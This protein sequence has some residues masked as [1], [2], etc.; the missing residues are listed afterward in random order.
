MKR[1]LIKLE[2]KGYLTVRH[3]QIY[4]YSAQ[5]AIDR[6]R[7]IYDIERVCEVWEKVNDWK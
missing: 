4:A 3:Y 7:N 5:D 6:L 2:E 1:Y